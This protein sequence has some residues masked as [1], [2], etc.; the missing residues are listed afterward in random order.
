MKNLFCAVFLIFLLARGACADFEFIGKI[1]THRKYPNLVEFRLSNAK[2]LVYVID[3]NIIR[4]RYVRKK[5]PKSLSYSV[6]HEGG[7]PFR[8]RASRNEYEIT[9]RELKVRIAKDPC[10]IGIYDLDG[11]LINEDEKSFGA[12]YDNDEVRCFKRLLPDEKF[13]GLGEKTGDLNRRGKQFTM[14]NS[15]FPAYSKTQDPLYVSIPFFI[16]VRDRKGYGIFFDN[17]YRSWFNMGA[18]NNRFYWFGA[19]KGELDYYFIYGPGIKRVVSSY[20]KLTGRMQLPPMW[21]LGYQQ[22]KWSYFPDKMVRSVARTFREKQIPCDVL[23]LDIDYMDDYRVFTWDPD[24]F[25]DPKEMLNDLREEGFKV[26]PI[27]DPGVKADPTLYSVA[28]EGMIQNHFI[29]YPDG[30]YYQGEVWPS[31]AYFPDFTRKETR[32]WWGNNLG[33]LL[34]KGVQGFW[35]DMNEPSAWGQAVPE[36][37]QFYDNGIG[38]SLKKIRN[39]YALEMAKATH[40]ALLE[41][42]GKRHLILSRSG[43]AGIQRYAAVWT[44]DNASTQ[45]HLALACVMLQGMGLSG[46][47]FVGSDVGGFIGVPTPELYIR[48]MQLGVFS[49][50]FRGHNAVNTPDKEPWAFGLE[51]EKI[52]K[53]AISLRYRLLPFLYNEFYNS[54]VTGLPIMRPMFLDFQD[55]GECYS[56]ECQYQFMVGENLLVAPVLNEKEFFKKIYLPEGRWLELET[57]KIYVGKQWV[58]IEV[59][60]SVI[61]L[62]LRE[63]GFIPM[64]EVQNFVGEKEMTQLELEIFPSRQSEFLLYEDDGLTRNYQDGDYTLTKFELKKDENIEMLVTRTKDGFASPRQRYLIKF[65]GVER[66]KGVTVDG[67]PETLTGGSPRRGVNLQESSFPGGIVDE[68]YSYDPQ[69]K[70]ITIKIRDGKNFSVICRY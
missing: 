47:P 68:G 14:W 69:E 18:S 9:T 30:E 6:I 11:N 44:G 45:E 7:V 32:T 70:A 29:K 28:R 10:R 15:D 55:D 56:S 43:F 13:Y 65:H 26:I 61:P 64:Q 48:W 36:L 52:V 38:A 3:E 41:F 66:P 1:V 24:K 16:G 4:F 8:V 54:S 19:E 34:K 2:L 5:T 67:V 20:A 27:I 23:Y 21:A 40:D 58:N 39:V 60:L 22:S 33:R 63:G 51:A 12:S 17:T 42:S 46:L 25:P 31:W 59:P 57:R 35:N 62:F 49:P 50:F 53:D 37:V